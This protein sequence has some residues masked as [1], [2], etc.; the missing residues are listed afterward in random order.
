[1]PIYRGDN[2]QVVESSGN[3][4]HDLGIELNAEEEFKNAIAKEITRL[5]TARGYT[6]KK[7]AEMLGTDQAKVS[8]ITRGRLSGFSAERLIRFLLSLGINVDVHLS[9]NR[10]REGRVTVHAPMAACG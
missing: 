10:D 6:Q 3:V 4:F 5:I 2:D 8:Q 9:T 7:V 1:M